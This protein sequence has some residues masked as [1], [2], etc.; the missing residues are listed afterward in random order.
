MARQAYKKQH[1]DYRVK[2]SLIKAK[3]NKSMRRKSTFVNQRAYTIVDQIT[4][5]TKHA[6]D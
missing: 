3:L 1:S 2:I 4:E 6:E 5:Y